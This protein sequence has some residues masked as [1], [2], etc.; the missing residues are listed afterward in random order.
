MIRPSPKRTRDYAHSRVAVLEPSRT[1][2]GSRGIPHRERY[3]ISFRAC[4]WREKSKRRR[5]R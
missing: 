1:R 3:S 4:V 5:A 2:G